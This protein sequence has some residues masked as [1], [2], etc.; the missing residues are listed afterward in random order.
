MMPLIEMANHAS[1]GTPAHNLE[2]LF[3]DSGAMLGRTSKPVAAGE[4]L[5]LN[6]L[7]LAEQ[8]L[9]GYARRAKL[10]GWGFDCACLRCAWRTRMQGVLVCWRGMWCWC[11][12]A[13]GLHITRALDELLPL[14]VEGLVQ[15]LR[16][17]PGLPHVI[18]SLWKWR[19]APC[20]VPGLPHV[21]ARSEQDRD[22]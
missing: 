15:R 11:G 3:D 22:R 19:Q 1:H 4:E 14:L 9:A 12:L 18:L 7:G 16:H 5:C 21:L 13:T 2:V 8:H 20:F 6:Y 17:V 10:H